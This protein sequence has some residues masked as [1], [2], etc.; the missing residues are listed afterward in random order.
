MKVNKLISLCQPV[1]TSGPEP[2]KIGM[3]RQDSRRV[4]HGDV[5]IAIRG[6]Q[7]D[8]HLFINDAVDKGASVIICEAGEEVAADKK[9]F[10]LKV[11]DTR[12]LTGHLAQHFAGNPADKMKVIGVT[13]TNGKTTV[14]TLTYQVML[15]LGIN[16]ALLGTVA[17]HFGENVV[18]SNLT[19]ADPIELAEDM[20][21]M[22]KAGITHLVMEVSSH[23][24]HQR[25][26][27]GIRFD[28]AAFTNL[29][30]DHLDYH[31]SLGAY[32][33]AKKMLFDS[34]DS[35]ATAI[36]NGDD[37]QAGFM[38]SGCQADT[39][40]F[41]FNT[42]SFNTDQN[43]DVGCQVLDNST[44]GLTVRIGEALVK[45][46]LMGLFNAYNIAEAFL[47][48]RALGFDDKMIAEALET[49]SGA[50]GRLER[51][52]V[53]TGGTEVNQPTVL[54]DYAHTPDALENVSATISGI[55]AEHQKL[56]IIFGCGGN[57]DK[58]KRPRMAAAVE[59][60]ADTITI[61]SD[62]PRDEDPESIIDEA[63]KGFKNRE[64]VIRSADRKK[65]IVQAIR[66]GSRDTIIL[67]AG[68]GHETYQEIKGRRYEFDDRQVAREAL[69]NSNANTESAGA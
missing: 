56:H 57:R 2:D 51:V 44:A 27:N 5:F 40:T 35:K 53:S 38:M 48:C 12:S 54:V 23:A 22:A 20:K 64:K 61:T 14:S 25:R 47:I 1:E 9:V 18:E 42:D 15:K 67:I 19:T 49:A 3:L 33:R 50:P 58:A 46:E 43:R 60:Y 13:G 63:M 39:V 36:F 30:H 65:A 21:Q 62:N 11:K 28:I 24:L 26:V 32:R 4:E 6:Q 45:S 68:K 8:G 34:L 41:S 59:P 10:I 66:H 52:S 55:K 37:E 16:A 17:K 7:T 69:S 31:K 29:S